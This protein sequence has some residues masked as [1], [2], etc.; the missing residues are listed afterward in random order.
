M[1]M[2]LFISCLVAAVAVG[3]A[4]AVESS[5]GALTTHRGAVKTAQ[6]PFSAAA[7]PLSPSTPAGT[8]ASRPTP[9]HARKLPAKPSRS[10]TPASAPS[11][12][13]SSP[14]SRPNVQIPELSLPAGGNPSTPQI[15]GAVASVG[16]TST[17]APIG[18]PGTDN[19][20]YPLAPAG[21]AV[22][23]YV[24]PGS[25]SRSHP[26]D[27]AFYFGVRG[28]TASERVRVEVL[29]PAGSET[30]F[31]SDETKRCGLDNAQGAGT[32]SQMA[33]TGIGTA[34][35]SPTGTYLVFVDLIDRHLT[36]RTTY[37]VTG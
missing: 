33:Q 8:T 6:S 34:P 36:I 20:P 22:T 3:T 17:S 18:Y 31:C 11:T 10:A 27:Q 4:A 19:G 7:P 25:L 26:N 28:A 14:S 21:Y 2:A 37:V 30:G 1:L 24:T 16:P 35:T 15:V 32:V 29:P 5:N 9:D 23:A 12:P 13:A